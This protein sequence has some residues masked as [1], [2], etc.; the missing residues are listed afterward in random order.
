MKLPPLSCIRANAIY[1]ATHRTLLRDTHRVFV[2]LLLLQWAAAIL[3]A[4]FVSPLTWKGLHSSTHIHVLTAFIVGGFINAMPLYLI[5]TAPDA[6]STRHAVTA[7]QLMWSALLIHLSGGRIETHFH[8]F[9]SLAFVAFYRDWRLLITGIVVT[10]GDHFVRGL[11]W[12]ESVYGVQTP[13]MWRFVEHAGWVVFESVVLVFACNRSQ[14]EMRVAA[15]REAALENIQAKIESEVE[16]KTAE[17][18]ETLKKNDALEDELLQA[19]K[20][21]AVGRLAAGV[22]HEINTPIQFVSDSVHFVKTGIDDLTRFSDELNEL[23]KADASVPSHAIVQ[24]LEEMD[25]EYLRERMPKA[26]DRSIDGLERVAEIVR[27]MKSFAHPD[28][29]EMT[30]ADI[31]SAI[32]TTLIVAKSEYKYLADISLELGELPHVM[33]HVGELNQVFI[34]MIV[35]A[36]HAIE[37]AHGGNGQMGKITIKTQMAD[38]D[39]VSISI[40]DTGSGIRKENLARVFEPFFTTK[41]VGKGTGQGLTIAHSVITKKHGGTVTVQSEVGQGTTFIIKLPVHQKIEAA[42]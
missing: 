12:P 35:N 14:Q 28:Q 30:L 3:F 8:V 5:R 34:N 4:A 9:G 31:N 1:Q 41:E 27:S 36:A 6:P 20:L 39:T 2:Y 18:L 21:E 7:G 37:D 24:K 42:A 29:K 23:A 15:N 25:Y 17:L 26:A 19:Q 22:A 32:Q 16:R 11:F 10:A 33:C 38:R 40:S 13:D